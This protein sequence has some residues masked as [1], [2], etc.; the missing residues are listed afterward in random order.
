MGWGEHVARE[1]ETKNEYVDFL[2]KRESKEFI[3]KT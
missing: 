3:W 1:G 2:G